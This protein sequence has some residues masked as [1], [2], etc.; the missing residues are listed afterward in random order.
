VNEPTS[1][2]VKTLLS[3]D[4]TLVVWWGTQI[5]CISAFMRQ[6][7]EG[8]LSASG[9]RQARQVL[10]SLIQSWIEMLPSEAVRS[11]AERLL[12]VHPLRAADALQLAAALQWRRDAAD[13]EFVSF[14]NRL[15]E[16]AYK[17]RFLLY[18]LTLS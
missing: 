10:G 11:T 18:P 4:P 14:D 15:R 1:A 2:E 7:R 3:D 5:E 16:A 12:V 6:V 9:E 17:E 8:N 13:Y